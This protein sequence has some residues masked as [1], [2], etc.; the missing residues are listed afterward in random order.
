MPS[1]T[2]PATTRTSWSPRPAV[3]GRPAEELAVAA[4]VRRVGRL[5]IGRYRRASTC[6]FDDD[7]SAT[8]TLSIDG[9]GTLR[10]HARARAAARQLRRSPG[11]GCARARRRPRPSTASASGRTT[12]TTAARSARC[13]SRSTRTSRAST[14][15]THVPIPLLIGTRGWG[16]FVESKRLGAVRRRH[17]GRRSGRDHLRHGAAERRRAALPSLCRRAPARHHQA[18]LRRHRLPAAAGAVGAR[19]VDLARREPR[20]GRRCSTTST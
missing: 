6:V 14:T 10:R 5:G 8:L 12:S 4:G 13:R 20:P 17:A 11:C 9:T 2:A 7:R 1:T 19:A 16:L 18:L 15:R 3:S